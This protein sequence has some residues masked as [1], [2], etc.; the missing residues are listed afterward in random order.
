MKSAI[1]L[2]LIG[3]CLYICLSL[4]ANC[5]PVS[6]FATDAQENTSQLSLEDIMA[7]VEKRYSITGFSAS[8]R[9]TSTI[10]AMEIT[11]NASGNITVKRPGKMRWEY[12]QPDPQVIITDGKTLWV[13][14]PQDNQVMVG[15]Y[16]TFFGD[17]RGASFLSD[18][19]LI[20]Q[21]FTITL[22]S[23]TDDGHLILK[24]IPQNTGGDISKIDLIISINTFD[25]V[26]IT[27]TNADGD[28]TQIQLKDIQFY[29]QID[30]HLFQFSI[31]DN[32]D[33]LQ[34]D[35]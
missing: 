18:M 24:L 34:M 9:Q 8:F 33:V 16:P 6:V 14:K 35:Q 5:F 20:R 10:K 29:H 21:K 1:Q 2:V 15:S 32:M 4:L 26:Q 19:N 23:V 28:E 22:E 7:G 25:I 13:Y 30:D 27:T 17:G 11:D 31:Q 12:E 3:F